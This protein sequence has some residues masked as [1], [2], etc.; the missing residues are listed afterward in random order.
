R[1]GQRARS[2]ARLPAAPDRGHPVLL[3]THVVRSRCRRRSRVEL[4]PARDR[5]A[6]RRREPGA[7]AAG[8]RLGGFFDRHEAALAA[9]AERDLAVARGEDRVV[10]A[11]AGAGA[12]PEARPA[13]ADEDHPRRHVLA[14]E[15]L[16]A[17]HLG[18]RVA[19]VP[20]RAES[21]LVCHLLV[22]QCRFERRERALASLAGALLL[23]RSLEL[24]AAPAGRCLGDLRD[25]HRLD[26]GA[27]R[28]G[29]LGLGRGLRLCL[30]LLLRLRLRALRSA[31]RLDLDP[32]QVAPVA[33]VPLVAGAL[34]VLADPDLLAELVPDNARRHS[35]RRREIRRA[36]AA[37]E[38]DARLEGRAL[39][40]AQS[41][42]EQP[43]GLLD[44]VLLA[45]ETDDRVAVHGVETRALR[46]RGGSVANGRFRSRQPTRTWGRTRNRRSRTRARRRAVAVPRAPGPRRPHSSRLSPLSSAGAPRRESPAES[47]FWASAPRRRRLSPVRQPL[48]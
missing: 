37:D 34:A 30:R 7:A 40:L 31:D 48:R 46:P 13:L 8:R 19:A 4:F 36:V 26:V 6:R 21:L 35:G 17:E 20:R 2:R 32:R 42:D 11:E 12:G 44:A 38:Q 25:C 23:E 5:R 16:H 29:L 10:L 14:A 47:S 39:V 45:A 24:L 43:L 22:L 3:P 9:R 15:E 27:C 1:R 41:V 33:G 18:L 28:F